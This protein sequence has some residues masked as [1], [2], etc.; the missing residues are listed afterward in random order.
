MFGAGFL[1]ASKPLLIRMITLPI[2]SWL[3]EIHEFPNPDQN[4][5][6]YKHMKATFSTEPNPTF[7]QG[8]WV[9]CLFQ[10]WNAAVHTGQLW[11]FCLKSLLIRLAQMTEVLVQM[12]SSPKKLRPF[13]HFSISDLVYILSIS[14]PK[15]L[16]PNISL[17]SKTR[18][19]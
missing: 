6:L 15:K 11:G 13:I 8:R 16:V 10:S 9:D 5:F 1:L 19:P 14:S 18:D 12:T 4:L 3:V 7:D 2:V 17:P